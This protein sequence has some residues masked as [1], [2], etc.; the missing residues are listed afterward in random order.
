[1]DHHEFRLGNL[2]FEVRYNI[3]NQD[4]IEFPTDIEFDLLVEFDGKVKSL[5]IKNSEFIGVLSNHFCTEIFPELCAIE[6]EERKVEAM[7]RRW[8]PV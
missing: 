4:G 2:D 8:W 1:M 7:E 3:D 5:P 6:A